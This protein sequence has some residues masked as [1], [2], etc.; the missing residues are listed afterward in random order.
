M[1]RGHIPSFTWA[2]IFHLCTILC[3]LITPAGMHCP[4]LSSNVAIGYASSSLLTVEI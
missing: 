3:M 1:S 2:N 4:P